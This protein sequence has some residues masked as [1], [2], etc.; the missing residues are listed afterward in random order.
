MR[1]R[2]WDMYRIWWSSVHSVNRY[3]CILETSFKIAIIIRHTRHELIKWC[4]K[5][6]RN[7]QL[8]NCMFNGIK[9]GVS[10]WQSG[11]ILVLLIFIFSCISFTFNQ[12]DLFDQKLKVNVSLSYLAIKVLLRWRLFRVPFLQQSILTLYIEPHKI[13]MSFY[14][15]LVY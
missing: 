4:N 11:R 14:Y 10:V 1:K 2:R 7:L 5:Y 6:L 9:H 13:M 12:F 3:R 15:F 8:N